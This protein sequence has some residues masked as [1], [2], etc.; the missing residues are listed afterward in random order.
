MAFHKLRQPGIIPMGKTMGAPAYARPALRWLAATAAA[1]LTTLLL[2]WLGANST[3]AGMVFLVLVVWWATQSGTVLSVY[4]AV[5]CAI[6]FD[7]YFLPP[8]HT[9]RLQGAQAWVAMVSFALSCVV[10]SRLSERARQQT[11]QARTTPG[12][13]GKALRPQPGDDAL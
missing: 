10:V 9:F 1:A 12:G 4:T 11:I 7:Y 13:R 3:T 8:V 6:C 5:L 2:A